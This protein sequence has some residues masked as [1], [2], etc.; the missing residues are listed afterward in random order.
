MGA[1]PENVGFHTKVT[2][3][4]RLEE[5]CRSDITPLSLL[6]INHIYLQTKKIV[7]SAIPYWNFGYLW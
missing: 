2:Y 6:S 3:L 5:F 7:G 4:K 1:D